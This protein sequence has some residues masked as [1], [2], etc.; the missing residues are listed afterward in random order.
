MEDLNHE[1]WFDHINDLE[2]Q[3]VLEY[4][5]VAFSLTKGVLNVAFFEDFGNAPHGWGTVQDRHDFHSLLQEEVPAGVTVT[6]SD[7][8]FGDEENHGEPD[9]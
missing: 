4:R 6:S 2:N 7:L 5:M 8:R 1:S 9:R 3:L